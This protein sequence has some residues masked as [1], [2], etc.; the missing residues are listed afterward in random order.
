MVQSIIIFTLLLQLLASA[1][2]FQTAPTLRYPHLSAS[3]PVKLRPRRQ[4]LSSGRTFDSQNE[5][6]EKE[7]RLAPLSPTSLIDGAEK[8]F[9]EQ[10]QQQQQQS[11][12]EACPKEKADAIETTKAVR[13]IQE[14]NT[15]ASRRMIL[16]A[17]TIG[18]GSALGAIAADVANAETTLGN[19]KWE[20]TPVNKRTGVTV[21]D[22]E[23]DG[24]NV[25]FV[26]YLSRFLLCFDE[27]CQ[28]W[29]YSK[30]SDI[31]RLSK[32][33]EIEAIRL[34]QFASFSASV[35]VGLQFYRGAEGVKRLLASL[36]KRYCP[37]LDSIRGSRLD[38]GLPT[39]GESAEAEKLREIK[40][41]RRQV[42]ILFGL[43]EKNQPVDEISSILAAIDNGSIATVDIND[44]GAGYAPGYGAPFVMF[45]KPDGGPDYETA[46]GRAV[47][48]PN[49]KILR[50]DVINRGSGYAKPPTVTI[51]PPEAAKMGNGSGLKAAEGRAI[52]FSFGANKG[53]VERIVLTD[54][55]LGYT[56]KE[57]I[58]VRL[59]PPESEGRNGVT[60]TATAVLEYKVGDIMIVNGGSGYAVE[61]PIDV[62]VE[63]PP[64]TARVN[65]NDPMIAQMLS[66][67]KLLPT[68]TI[69]TKDVKKKMADT[70]DP[71][72]AAARIQRLAMNE[73]KGGGGGCVG[74]ACYDHSV[75][76]IAYARAAKN[77]YS[78][79]RTDDDATKSARMEANLMNKAGNGSN[80][81]VSG[82][83]SGIGNAPRLPGFGVS[84][85][86]QLL[87]L[88]PEGIGLQY[89]REKKRYLVRA[90]S[91]VLDKLPD[92]L[93]DGSSM[94]PRDPEFGMFMFVNILV[95][96]HERI[97]AVLVDT[98][99]N[100]AYKLTVV[101]VIALLRTRS[102][103]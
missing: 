2:A 62:Y 86:V 76:A 81:L 13:E 42:A 3:V 48:V 21:F 26:T 29:W 47:L 79:F 93:F 82:S 6:T 101:F 87:S 22:A 88:L 54:P 97:S 69:P 59:T 24:Y 28:R 51:E 100:Y 63:A 16:A 35:E 102:S 56:E 41:A 74:R 44:E 96:C 12:T 52:L 84:S 20:A 78:S 10:Q 14:L 30:A 71:T 53:R 40:E 19:L 94:K 25:A 99:L 66:A 80:E 65:M 92:G 103:R 50:L 9:L 90:T 23:K 36:L 39:L 55:G 11:Y 5:Y 37:D 8:I 85:S 83:T 31:P 43:M 46:I 89:D 33:E 1:G 45:P 17:A 95:L 38:A 32:K 91:E 27:D 60:A 68:T 7:E 98:S 34:Q 4:S 72:S 61:K 64:P 73:G 49:G 15:A 58:K 70:N 18:L 75:E 77:S 67:D 57:I